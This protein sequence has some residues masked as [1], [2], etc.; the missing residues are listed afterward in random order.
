MVLP[1]ILD[2]TAYIYHPFRAVTLKCCGQYVDEFLYIF[3]CYYRFAFQYLLSLTFSSA[4]YFKKLNSLFSGAF[5]LTLLLFSLCA[6]AQKP[7]LDSLREINRTQLEP[8]Q[9]LDAVLR[10]ARS[11]R[12]SDFN[13]RLFVSNQGIYLAKALNDSVKLAEMYRYKGVSYYFQGQFDS[14][15]HYLY[16]SIQILEIKKDKQQLGESLNALGKLYRKK[17]EFQ[18]ATNAYD[19]AMKLFTE[20]G[21]SSGIA[22]IYNESGVVY[23]YTG[24]YNEAMRRYRASL[25]IQQLRKDDIGIS[26]SLS[27]IGYLY[28]TLEDYDKAEKY[29]QDALKIRMQYN[30]SFSLA[31]NYTELGELSMKRKKMTEASDY[32]LK[33]NAIAFPLKYL[34]LQMA[35]YR[36][37]SDVA[38]IQGNY[39]AAF[40]Y[41]QNFEGLKDSIYRIESASRIEEI[42]TRYETEKKANEN[43]LLKKTVS[44]RDLEIRDKENQNRLQ[45]ITAVSMGIIFFLAIILGLLIFYRIRR[46]QQIRLLTE[47][48]TAREGER[49]RISRDLHDHLGAQMSYMISILEKAGESDKN[50]KYV[51]ALRDTAGQAIMTL[52]ETVWAINKNEIS[53][54]NFSDKFKQYAFKQVE[55]SNNIE[56][57]FKEGIEQNRVLSPGVALNLYRLCQEAFSNSVKHAGA[58]KIV[59]TVKSDAQYEFY[60]S[61]KD[62]GA[63]FNPEKDKKEGHYGLENMR[64]RAG[65]AGAEFAIHSQA[66]GGTTVEVFSLSA[67]QN[68][69]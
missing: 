65:E 62:D 37:L 23:E 67:K 57:S 56:V 33:S 20:I 64:Y 58:N 54:E 3:I 22:T 4:L 17:K 69:V 51:P 42:S 11:S 50:N 5:C 44:L 46:E 7:V 16:S 35:N 68:H 43:E 36:L 26:Y 55:F 29:L 24:D 59:V 31:L 52:R 25:E 13:E 45:L 18:R 49:R 32:F 6:M 28:I 34:D 40:N 12:L 1:S 14:T 27:N 19:R 63:G 61:V 53:V 48:N 21:D 15:A 41:Y 38:M 39:K 30:D 10:L 66:G 47:V 2:A 8:V 60:F 9:K